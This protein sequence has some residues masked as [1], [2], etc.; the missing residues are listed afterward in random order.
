VWVSLSRTTGKKND[1]KGRRGNKKA[2]NEGWRRGG[3]GEGGARVEGGGKRGEGQEVPGILEREGLR[4][5]LDSRMLLDYAGIRNFLLGSLPSSHRGNR[6]RNRCCPTT[7]SRRAPCRLLDFSR[8]LVVVSFSPSASCSSSS[9][10]SSSSSILE[11]G[12]TYSFYVL[13]IRK[14]DQ[15]CSFEQYTPGE[16]E[17]G[18]KR[19]EDIICLKI[20][21]LQKE[22]EERQLSVRLSANRQISK[23]FA[24]TCAHICDFFFVRDFSISR[25]TDNIHVVDIKR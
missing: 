10:S 7:Q 1:R 4:A 8:P 25:E 20:N 21:I 13:S 2:R 12:E 22:R 9:S 5:A 15:R 3:G 11:R 24:I 19:A 14:R 17:R 18:E 16:T 23:M 6:P